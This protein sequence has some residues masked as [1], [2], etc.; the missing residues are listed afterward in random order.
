MSH[1][2]RM[3]PLEPWLRTAPPQRLFACGE[4][5]KRHIYA[6]RD[7]HTENVNAKRDLQQIPAKET[8]V[9]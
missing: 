9:C 3:K 5:Q 2:M 7:L 1:D 4:L 6:K 8:Y